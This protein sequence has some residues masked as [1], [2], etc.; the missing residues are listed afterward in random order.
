MGPKLVAAQFA[1]LG[2]K[3]RE[4]EPQTG[5]KLIASQ[6]PS[7]LRP[8]PYTGSRAPQLP[9]LIGGGTPAIKQ[10]IAEELGL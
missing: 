6:F 5:S 4:P 8:T 10:A 7:S 3:L 1:S 9:S 2:V